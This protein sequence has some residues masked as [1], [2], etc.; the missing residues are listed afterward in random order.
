MDDFFTIFFFYYLGNYGRSYHIISYFYILIYVI[1]YIY[2]GL[3][4]DRYKI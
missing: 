1:I 3:S 2:S 4:K